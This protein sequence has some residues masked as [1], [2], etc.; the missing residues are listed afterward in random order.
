MA[1]YRFT[2]SPLCVCTKDDV[3]AVAQLASDCKDTAQWALYGVACLC[4]GAIF[5]AM[6]L[7]A[8]VVLLG[9]NQLFLR[10]IKRKSSR[11][12]VGG[13]RGELWGG[14]RSGTTCC[15]EGSCHTLLHVL[16]RHVMRLHGS[17][18]FL[19]CC[20]C[21][22]SS[23][24]GSARKGDEAGVSKQMMSPSMPGRSGSYPFLTINAAA[25]T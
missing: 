8:D 24:R 5:G 19:T 3:Q 6:E 12:G 10:V 9:A 11:C 22:R 18:V 21:C 4:V 1:L 16:H 20:C 7:S 13:G 17:H 23:S 2:E 14:S 25:H 15:Q